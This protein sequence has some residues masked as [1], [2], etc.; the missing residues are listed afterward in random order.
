[1]S[2]QVLRINVDSLVLEEKATDCP[3]SLGLGIDDL[4]TRLDVRRE[5]RS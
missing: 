3:A 2:L 4:G 1:M 5:A